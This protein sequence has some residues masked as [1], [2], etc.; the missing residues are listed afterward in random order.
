[1][2]RR[3]S[4]FVPSS[5]PPDVW[6]RIAP[7]VRRAA[8][9]AGSTPYSATALA[10]VTAQLLH[11]CDREGLPLRD[12]VVLHPDTVDRFIAAGCGHLRHG[13]RL[14]YQS[15]LRRVGELLVGP[16]LYPT[17]RY[18]TGS[19]DPIAPYTEEEVA[20]LLGWARGLSTARM[21][22]NSLVLLSFGLGVGLTSRELNA[23]VG[24]DVASDDDGVLVHVV[25]GRRRRV[26]RVLRRW[27]EH[28]HTHA[29]RVGGKGYSCRAV[30]VSAARTSAASW[31][32]VLGRMPRS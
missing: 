14:N 3:I 11:W 28:V 12:E 30:I 21:R 5:V 18:S 13:T 24:T 25:T 2:T 29:E 10:S 31:R 16:P 8:E 23:L 7:S 9:R 22:Q 32:V 4:R 20:A 27:E 26:V 6:E 15:Q 1:M 17:R 19:S